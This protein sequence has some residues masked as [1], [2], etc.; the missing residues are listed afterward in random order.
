MSRYRGPRLRIIR[1]L[2][3]LPGFTSK[4]TQRTSPPGQ[5]GP[6]KA[7]KKSSLS[8]YGIRLQEKQKLRYNYGLS[9][10]QLFNYVK[11]ARRL[12]GAT[13]PLLLQMLEMRL[14]SVIFR[15]GLAPT[16]PSARQIVTHGGI[17]INGKKV[18]IPS[19]QCKPKDIV[20]LK[21]KATKEM[22]TK[23][24]EG[25]PRE[26]PSHLEFDKDNAKGTVLS[27]INRDDIGLEINELLI[28]EFYSRR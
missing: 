17:K 4:T 10:S 28:V 5:H 24:M 16:I 27:I 8:E 21:S 12:P 7:G 11:E 9:E 13:G 3:E 18:N 2:G 26:I 14:D 19:F 1:R 23:L 22:V 25:I 15:L 6:S 20:E